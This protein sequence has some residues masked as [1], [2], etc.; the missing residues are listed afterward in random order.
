MLMTDGSDFDDMLEKDSDILALGLKI[1]AMYDAESGA[2]KYVYDVFFP[3]DTLAISQVIGILEY[4]KMQML[5][6]GVDSL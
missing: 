3:L 1:A 2:L 4:V 5:I 6:D